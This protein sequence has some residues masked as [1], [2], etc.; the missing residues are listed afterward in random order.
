M[1]TNGTPVLIRPA[2]PC[3]HGVHLVLTMLTLGAW[4]PF[5]LLAWVCSLHP[6]RKALI[7]YH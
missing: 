4:S 1:K 6:S 7:E 5:W 3:R 2:R